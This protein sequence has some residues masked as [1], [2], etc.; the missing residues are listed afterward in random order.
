M[1]DS[2]H[3]AAPPGSERILF[4]D[5]GPITL[6]LYRVDLA[7]RFDIDTAQSGV[8]AL[9]CIARSG[10]Y[11]AVVADLHMPDMTGVE[12]LEQVGA[13]S[14]DSVRIMITSEAR[15]DVNFEAMH[16]SNVQ[17]FLSKPCP[18]EVLISALEGAVAAY[19]RRLAEQE[20]LASTLGSSVELMVEMLSEVKPL[21]FERAQRVKE[22]VTRLCDAL[23]VRD[24]WEIATAAML[25]QLGCLSLPDA[26]LR[27]VLKGEELS[28]DER[29]LYESH[30]ERGGELVGK[31]P[32][33][34][35]VA[36]IVARQNNVAAAST[37][38]ES[39]RGGIV[40][41]ARFLKLA[42]E[43][44]ALL[45]QGWAPLQATASL[46]SCGACD[47]E[48]LEVLEETLKKEIA[49]QTR[50]IKLC[51]FVPGMVLAEDLLDACG[52]VL[53]TRGQ[54]LTS[55]I[56]ERLQRQ[57]EGGRTIREPI[58]VLLP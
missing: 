57:R 38:T 54:E 56:L 52:A 10:P 51:E 19:R 32:R 50:C 23:K 36:G 40:W 49:L 3:S 6:D 7:G 27:K 43:Y 16:R 33:L 25:S 21:A 26:L 20:L 9:E 24:A 14:P 12:L 35:R 31:I 13:V 46:K 45:E 34:K 41:R 11:A 48:L 1:S 53:V 44:D 2:L 55:W 42:I 29:R 37:L 4:V 39:M 47:P 5:D 18:R 28:R 58:R 17:D 8:E 30:P 22:I 15:R